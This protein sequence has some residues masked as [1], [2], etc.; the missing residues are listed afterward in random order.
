MP[1]KAMAP[2]H[3]ALSFLFLAAGTYAAPTGGN[4]N[5]EAIDTYNSWTALLTH[6]AP[7]LILLGEKHVKSY[8]RSM[9]STSHHVL[10]AVSPI[11]LTTALVSLIRLQ[12]APF[13][14]RL[15]GREYE[16]RQQVL[17]DISSISQGSV[18]W[19]FKGDKEMTQ[20]DVSPRI[21]DRARFQLIFG[22]CGGLTDA[23]QFA[24]KIEEYLA[25]GRRYPQM[26]DVSGS[27][28]STITASGP[29]ARDDARTS[30][31]VLLQNNHGGLDSADRNPASCLVQSVAYIS[32]AGVSPVLSMAANASNHFFAAA[33]LTGAVLCLALEAVIIYVDWRSQHSI[34]TTALLSGGLIGLI[35]SCWIIT[36]VVDRS[37][38]EQTISWEDLNPALRFAGFSSDNLPGRYWTKVNLDKV[39]I[40]RE[41]P[42]IFEKAYSKLP[43]SSKLSVWSNFCLIFASTLVPCVTVLS[44]LAYIALYLGFLSARWWT[45]LSMLGVFGIAALMRSATSVCVNLQGPSNSSTDPFQSHGDNHWLW[46]LMDDLAK[47]YSLWKSG[48]E[49]S[50]L[51]FPA[52]VF[53][54]TSENSVLKTSHS[55][56]LEYQRLGSR[57]RLQKSR[58]GSNSSRLSQYSQSSGW[59]EKSDC[60]RRNL[61]THPWKVVAI[62]RHTALDTP[63][64]S[65]SL[66]HG[67]DCREPVFEAH[68]VAIL[69]GA[70]AIAAEMRR[71]SLSLHELA[72][73]NYKKPRT[74][75]YSKECVFIR[76]EFIGG[77]SVW[78][79][80]LDIA[81]SGSWLSDDSILSLLKAWAS[82]ALCDRIELCKEC[83]PDA[84]DHFKTQQITRLLLPSTVNIWKR[85]TS[86]YDFLQ[87]QNVDKQHM[88][89]FP[90]PQLYPTSETNQFPTFSSVQL[91]QRSLWCTCY[92]LWMAVKI[93]SVTRYADSE[94]QLAERANFYRDQL[95]SNSHFDPVSL[96]ETHL[97]IHHMLSLKLITRLP[98]KE[99]Y[100]DKYQDGKPFSKTGVSPGSASMDY[101]YSGAT[102]V[103]AGTPKGSKPFPISG[104]QPTFPSPSNTG[105][106][107]ISNTGKAETE[108]CHI[109][110]HK[111]MLRDSNEFATNNQNPQSNMSL[112]KSRGGLVEGYRPSS[113]REFPLVRPP[114]VRPPPIHTAVSPDTKTGSR[115]SL[116]EAK[117]SDQNTDLDKSRPAASS[118][119]STFVSPDFSKNGE[120]AELAQL[121]A[122]EIG[123][124]NCEIPGDT[125][126]I[127]RQSGVEASGRTSPIIEMQPIVS[128]YSYETPTRSHTP[129]T[130]SDDEKTPTAT[131]TGPL[132]VSN[133]TEQNFPPPLPFSP[134]EVDPV[135]IPLPNSKQQSREASLRA[136]TTSSARTSNY[137]LIEPPVE[138]SPNGNTYFHASAIP[139]RPVSPGLNLAESM[140]GNLSADPYFGWHPKDEG[141][142]GS[143]KSSGASV[144]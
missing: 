51:A 65:K 38:E 67:T 56:D 15:I 47:E 142:E 77:D 35:L 55:D 12:G 78:Q 23:L 134:P 3:K 8:F 71:Q 70:F 79:Q 87:T 113:P 120:I 73:V 85:K 141:D 138:Y 36:F 20:Q 63:L 43:W 41:R 69:Q 14:R 34:P 28:F 127:D 49:E 102:R 64:N 10:Y 112:A 52:M 1:Y 95:V 44:I 60:R 2:H 106:N 33:R 6:I 91:S 18:W 126:A 17:G 124:N 42:L 7:I 104:D 131:R 96:E 11:G 130:N 32:N 40:S 25:K 83:F 29:T 59:S 66:L 37:T 16:D 116:T 137:S 53:D 114:L 81:V 82:Q 115:T 74:Q 45:S 140:F 111:E 76:S 121:D 107:D 110:V 31:S 89:T 68:S 99:Y 75:K 62:E 24:Q 94:D 26:T 61:N 133:T 98:T 58:H 19:D 128:E 118:T 119:S 93:I 100:M 139:G 117:M 109:K 48:H 135:H 13:M 125:K 72:D 46:T 123:Q 90:T 105:F 57:G 88:D 86:L 4:P 92:A 101:R 80:S 5:T 136:P 27:V 143:T 103:E 50:T 9:S 129:V 132:R 39:V 30:A 84:D 144:Q 54:R 97:Y 122:L 22:N 108:D 21:H